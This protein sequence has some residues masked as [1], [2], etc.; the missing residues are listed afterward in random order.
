MKEKRNLNIRRIFSNSIIVIIFCFCQIHLFNAYGQ[1]RLA[2]ISKFT[3]D[4]KIQRKGQTLV[5]KKVGQRIT[6]SSMFEGDVLDTGA[7]SA[8]VVLFTD[9][10]HIKIGENATLDFNIRKLTDEEKAETGQLIARTINIKEGRAWGS[11]A[12][13]KTVLTEF[14]TPSG[15]A[16]TRSG[17]IDFST[18]PDTTTMDTTCLID[19]TVDTVT[20]KETIKVEA[21]EIVFTYA[22]TGNTTIAGT[23][24]TID[25]KVP[26]GEK[27]RTGPPEPDPGPSDDGTID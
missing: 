6:N 10:S 21:G 17:T 25:A 26:V 18:E 12:H 8:A 23:G 24:E 16:I 2:A 1:E 11:F 7:G 15:A 27:P 22:A 19:V 14:E 13:S 3:G 5:I 4:V 20:G 9:G